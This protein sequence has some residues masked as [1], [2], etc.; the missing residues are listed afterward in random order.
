MDEDDTQAVVEVHPEITGVDL[1]QQVFISSGHH[2]YI[3]RDLFI[4][5]NPCD[6]VFLEGTK[7]FGLCAE[8]HVA[9]LIQKQCTPIG[10]FKLTDA[11]LDGRSKG[12]FS[13]PNNSL[14]ISSLGMAAQ[15]TSISGPVAR[16]L[17]SWIHRATSSLPV[18][19][20]P[21]IRTVHRLEPPFRSYP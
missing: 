8:A 7:H 11:L 18:P 1:F 15:L 12:T 6:L 13:W 19:L 14:S 10:L 3:N 9:D 17:R 5:A 16:L 2:P 20:S 4:A 21:V